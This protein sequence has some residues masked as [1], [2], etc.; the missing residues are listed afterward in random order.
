MKRLMSV[1]NAFSLQIRIRAVQTI[2]VMRI[3]AV[4]IISDL[5]SEA[6]DVITAALSLAG[7]AL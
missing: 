1:T 3:I 6:S 2:V 7:T 4:Q 5:I